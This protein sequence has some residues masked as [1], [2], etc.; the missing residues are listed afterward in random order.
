MLKSEV[1]LSPIFRIFFSHYHLIDGMVCTRDD[2]CSVVHRKVSCGD[3]DRL[4]T[5]ISKEDSFSSMS[6]ILNG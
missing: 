4:D 3:R 5:N 1:C 2:C 6:F